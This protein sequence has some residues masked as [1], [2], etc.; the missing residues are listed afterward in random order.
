MLLEDRRRVI[1]ADTWSKSAG[2]LE[3]MPP[4]SCESNVVEKGRRMGF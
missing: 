2:R 3:L 4:L 1:E